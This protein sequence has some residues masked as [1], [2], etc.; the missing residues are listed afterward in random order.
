MLAYRQTLRLMFITPASSPKHHCPGTSLRG[1]MW[2]LSLNECHLLQRDQY[3]VDSLGSAMSIENSSSAVRYSLTSSGYPSSLTASVTS[4][5]SW[6]TLTFLVAAFHWAW[7]RCLS[8]GGIINSLP[9]LSIVTSRYDCTPFNNQTMLFL[10]NYFWHAISTL[11]LST[12]AQ[13]IT[14]ANITGRYA[15]PID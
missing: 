1:I 11:L 7:H 3:G 9:G 4:L 14:T 10:G 13:L 15:K 6:L 2:N 8:L 5:W 12:S